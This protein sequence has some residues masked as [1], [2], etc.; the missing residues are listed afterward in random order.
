M[1]DRGLCG[2]D[3][4]EAIVLV[5]IIIALILCVDAGGQRSPRGTVFNVV[6]CWRE[7][8]G[9]LGRTALLKLAA[10]CLLNGAKSTLAM[11]PETK[12]VWTVLR[13]IWGIRNA[14]H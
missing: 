14:L 10:E 3:R 12:L 1:V 5:L 11:L 7:N 4:H 8:G 13:A 9:P 6:P 2:S